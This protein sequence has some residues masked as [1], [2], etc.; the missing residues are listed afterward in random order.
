[1]NREIVLRPKENLSYY[2]KTIEIYL[3]FVLIRCSKYTNSKRLAEVIAVYT[4][5]CAYLLY[6]IM[7]GANKMIVIIDNMVGVI[8]EDLGKTGDN[9]ENG[10]LLFSQLNVLCAAKKLA[11]MDTKECLDE[12]QLHK[13]ISQSFDRNQ[14]VRIKTTVMNYLIK[15]S[16][17]HLAD[18]NAFNNG[19]NMR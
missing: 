3:P 12:I 14:L 7:D 11:E 13:G 6:K 8:G 9:Q 18:S 15:N 10:H 2:R 19:R 5:I 17:Q 16:S 4:F 1:M